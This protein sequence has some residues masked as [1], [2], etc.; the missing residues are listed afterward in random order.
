MKL[1]R[2]LP[3][4]VAVLL[5]SSARSHSAEDARPASSPAE[6][7]W[8]LAGVEITD[9]ASVVRGRLSNG[10]RYVIR[11]HVSPDRQLSLRL[12]VHAGSLHESDDERGFAHFVE[13]MA[14]NGTK[15]FPAG[16]LVKFL[17]R[18]GAQFGPHVNA[19]T[20][21]TSTLYKL[22]LPAGAPDSL[23]TGLRVFRD[24]ADGILFENAE[25]KRERG[26]ILS[27]LRTRNTPQSDEHRALTDLL[28]AGTRIPTRTP[29]GLPAQIE[30]ADRAA[31]RRFY[32]AWYR[33]ENMTVI[34]VGAISAPEVEALI[35]KQFASL[36]GRG[37]ARNDPT[38]GNVPAL[39]SPAITVHPRPLGGASTH[40]I[41]VTERPHERPTWGHQLHGFQ[42]NA[43]LS[44]LKERLKGLSRQPDSPIVGA[45][46]GIEVDYNHFRRIWLA[47]DSAPAALAPALT[48]VEQELRR[49]LEFG[50]EPEELARQQDILRR[51]LRATADSARTAPASAIADAFVDYAQDDSP[52]RLLDESLEPLLQAIDQLAPQNCRSALQDFFGKHA[53]RIFVSCTSAHAPTVEK[54]AE[55][56]RTSRERSLERTAPASSDAVF[57]YDNFG[58]PGQVAEKKYIAD[59]GLWQLRLA[60]DVRVNLK[61]TAFKAG[62]VQFAIRIGFG[63][64]AEPADKPGLAL[65]L[66]FLW[67]GGTGKHPAAEMRRMLGGLDGF[68]TSTLDD[69]S[70]LKGEVPRANLFFALR[71]LTALIADPAFREEGWDRTRSILRGYTDPLWNRPEGA[72]SQFILPLLAGG[73][74]R[75]GI[76]ADAKYLARTPDEFRAW[77]APQ[78]AAG[79]VELSLVGD[80]DVEAAI[81][82][83]TRTFATLPA[84]ASRTA[85]PFSTELRFLADR[86]ARR[87]YFNGTADRAS[88][89]EFFWRIREPVTPREH[90][91]IHM[92]AEIFGDRVSDEV[93][94]RKGSS[95]RV[96]AG[97][98]WNDVYP[99]FSFIR[100]S[101]D[102]QPADREKHTRAVRKLALA[103]AEKGVTADELARAKAQTLATLARNHTNNGYWLHDVLSDSQQRPFRLDAART[104]Q[105]DVE[106]ATVAELNAL[107]ARYLGPERVFHYV[108]EPS[109]LI[110]RKK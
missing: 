104:A 96:T 58:P 59:L 68:T 43:G 82:E 90:R 12:L 78:L 66:P 99:G 53:P 73:D 65:W 20:D 17:Q 69:A 29:I 14:F 94:E 5:L 106:S 86:K 9:G 31:L 42:V 44:I 103:L 49:Y 40:F 18:Q 83:I 54:I 48:L 62:H 37:P 30:R 23:A 32:D 25:V 75:L 7:P 13:H 101:V 34:V 102:H 97:V 27:E 41:S 76:P 46:S 84:R 11:P 21:H 108:I 77:L 92:L 2:G 79:P 100:C 110:P 72:V 67:E 109:A 64:L 57:G 10:L 15:H 71:E 16:E 4:L 50:I 3:L 85:S 93:R 91:L 24:F 36:A 95:Y 19:H 98:S 35:E 8:P 63:R 74:T 38:V 60:N 70:V 55:T 22:D 6:T 81:E 52:M 80:F 56:Y 33:P 89:W 47:V 61:P 1:L 87:Y 45:H 26:V 88:R 51:Q 107:A 39:T 28:Y 105:S